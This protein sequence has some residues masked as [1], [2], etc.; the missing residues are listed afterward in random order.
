[1]NKKIKKNLKQGLIGAYAG[2]LVCFVFSAVGIRLMTIWFDGTPTP[3]SA[4]VFICVILSFLLAFSIFLFVQ[5]LNKLIPYFKSLRALKYGVEDTAV[6]CDYSARSLKQGRID[7]MSHHFY[8]LK[9]KF[10]VDGKEVVFKTGYNY[11][12]KQFNQLYEKPEI[13]IKRYKNTAVIIEE[14]YDEKDYDFKELPK[15]LRICSILV[16]VMAWISLAILI[17]GISCLLIFEYTPW[18]LGILISG[19]AL[20]II[21]GIL[22]S[23]VIYTTEKFVKNTLPYIRKAQRRNRKK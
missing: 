6:L 4:I 7:H 15:K 20:I 21:S 2:L 19:I 8:S 12:Q 11:N 1:M 16:V 22:K 18:G 13:Q 3:V 23:F 17:S 5:S 10:F 9:L 14:F